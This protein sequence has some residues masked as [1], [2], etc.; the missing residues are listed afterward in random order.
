MQSAVYSAHRAGIILLP[1]QLSR[2]FLKPIIPMKNMLLLASMFTLML[3]SGL[4]WLDN[5]LLDRLEK[6]ALPAATSPAV[7]QDQPMPQITLPETT[8]R[9][10]TKDIRSRTLPEVVIRTRRCTGA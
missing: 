1:S 4:V 10:L 7:S 6:K 3:A 5:M 8:I 2:L 9:P